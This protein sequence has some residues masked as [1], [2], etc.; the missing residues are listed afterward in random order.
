M[1]NHKPPSRDSAISVKATPVVLRASELA[2]RQNARASNATVSSR[3]APNRA[4]YTCP[5]LAPNPAIPEARTRAFKLPSRVGNRL[6]YPDGTIE[7]L[8]P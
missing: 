8:K 1:P 6:H 7:E 4:P 2:K 5:E 3:W